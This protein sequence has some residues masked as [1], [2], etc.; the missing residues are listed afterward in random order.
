MF[1]SPRPWIRL[2]VA[3]AL[4]CCAASASAE[5]F[6][7]LRVRSGIK[8]FRVILKGDG[9]IAD[10][11]SGEEL[12]LLLVGAEGAPARFSDLARDVQGAGN[13][14][15]LPVTVRAVAASTLGEQSGP[16]AGLFVAEPLGEDALRK[17]VQ[18]GVDRHAISF[19]P[20]DG[21]VE[22]G[23]LCGVSFEAKVVPFINL[24][25]LKASGISLS[26]TVL[27]VAKTHD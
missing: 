24:K 21:D 7:D 5:S 4:A 14:A 6:E 13:I 25:T 2:A 27:K 12:V 23:V 15:N 3:A 17:T 26:P 16:V 1:D 10:K 18:F 8:I 20:F 22:R 9:G 11:K 19:S